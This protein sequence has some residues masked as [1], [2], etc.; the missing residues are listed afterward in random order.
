MSSKN[1]TQDWHVSDIRLSSRLQ[2]IWTNLIQTLMPMICHFRGSGCKDA[3][4]LWLLLSA[5]LGH[6]SGHASSV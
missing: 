6:Q 2:F 5:E 1:K 3:E 4:E